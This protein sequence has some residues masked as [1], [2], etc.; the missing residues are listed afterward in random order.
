MQ[1]RG[2]FAQEEKEKNRQISQ[3]IEKR[4]AEVTEEAYKNAEYSSKG[5]YGRI[6]INYLYRYAPGVHLYIGAKYGKSFYEDEGTYELGSEFWKNYKYSFQRTDLQADWFEVIIGSEKQW[7][8]IIYLGFVT[9]LRA[10]RSYDTFN[11]I[12]VY[13]IPGY[14]RTMDKTIPAVNLYIKF[15]L[16]NRRTQNSSSSE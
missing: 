3:E 12:E 5:F 1:Y 10:L 15:I 7:K 13:S 14:G 4:V 8:G 16:G 11:P 2:M 9:R 6:G